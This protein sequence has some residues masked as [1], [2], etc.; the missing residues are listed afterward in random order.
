MTM[1]ISKFHKLIQSKVVW[2]IVIAVIVLSFSVF[3]ISSY[4]LGGSRRG[5][6]QSVGKL[7]GEEVSRR[8]LAIA[9][10][11]II[12]WQVLTTGRMPQMDNEAARRLE[13]S[14]WR[15][16][17]MLRKASAEKMAVS[18][19]EVV[20][21]IQRMPIFE[22]QSGVFDKNIYNAIIGQLRQGDR[23]RG[24]TSDYVENMV[25]QQ[26]LLQKLAYRPAQAALIPP[27]ELERAYH[28]YSDRLVLDYAVF[29]SEELAPDV[30][31]S[32]EEAEALYNQNKEAFR[33]P[34][35]VR[36][37]YVDFPVA[38]FLA[39]ADVP[40]GAAL[41][42]YNQNLDAFRVETT[43]DVEAVAYKPFEEV[44]PQITENLVKFSARRLAVEAATALVADSSPKA[45]NEAPDFKG[46]VAAAGL[47]AKTLPAFGPADELKGIDPSAPFQKAALGLRDD[48]YSSFSDAIVGSNSV[49]VISLEQR[50][51]SFIPPFEA[52]EDDAM[53]AARTRAVREA[54]AQRL[55]EIHDAIQA[56]LAAGSDFKAAVEPYGVTVQT[57][58][59]F[60]LTSPPGTDYDEALMKASVN[61]E[62]GELCQI[63]PVEEDALIS[64]LV[65][66]KAVDPDLGLPALRDE[67]ISQLTQRYKQRVFVDWQQALA[68]EAGLQRDEN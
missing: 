53:E 35:K 45:Q 63:V 64:F 68:E 33:M 21:Q 61:V 17:V 4:V 13:D 14:A 59:E 41:Q 16:L 47:T 40:E 39:Q 58:P 46:A 49:Y 65:Q 18:N 54:E 2:Y 67:L 1:M 62:Q 56:A 23:F 32:R 66:R 8:E 10:N 3:G 7:F 27:Y 6:N 34:A 36:V 30:T 20:Q 22:S 51:E 48:I 25:R 28:L 5:R 37:S 50:Y 55:I 24:L 42:V 19:E 52:V 11:N 31:V 15:R 29:S 60:D 26:I 38:D 57:T 44:E 43:G 12:L 9:Q